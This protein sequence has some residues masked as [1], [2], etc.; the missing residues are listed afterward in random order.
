MKSL[1]LNRKINIACRLA[2]LAT[3]VCALAAGPS[4]S[5]AYSNA[6]GITVVNSSSREIR[7]LYLSP[8]GE[9]NWGPDQLNDARLTNGQSVTLSD[10]SCG[11]SEIKVIAEDS[12]GCFLSSVVSCG[13][14]AQW[15]ITNATSADCGS[16]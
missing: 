10:V 6:T 2:I 3:V 11:G 1:H 13:G 16:E 5:S 7:Y 4:R 9:D 8:V 12:D 15:T 14:A